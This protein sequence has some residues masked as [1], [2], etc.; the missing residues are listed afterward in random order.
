MTWAAVKKLDGSS[1]AVTNT[2]LDSGGGEHV[3]DDNAL[4]TSATSHLIFTA[5][6]NVNPV[7]IQEFRLYDNR[8]FS[9]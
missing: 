6:I 2:V 5:T 7:I 4:D 3:V 8:M 9:I 1:V